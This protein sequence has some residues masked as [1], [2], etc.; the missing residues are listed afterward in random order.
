MFR[1]RA[2]DVDDS[3]G[4]VGLRGN[5]CNIEW[6]HLLT[7]TDQRLGSVESRGLEHLAR[8]GPIS[9]P[10][11]ASVIQEIVNRSGWVSGNALAIMV[12]GS[13]RRTAE[14]YEGR[15]TGAP[16]LHVEYSPGS[17]TD[18]ARLQA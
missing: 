7:G 17:G 13:G 16:L 10:D 4:G 12:A 18:S 2:H 6:E 11:L 15:A 5:V 3:R 9:V 1:V 14:S 8:R